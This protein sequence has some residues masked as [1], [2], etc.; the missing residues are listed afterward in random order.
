MKQKT[1]IK[2]KKA[3]TKLHNDKGLQYYKDTLR[4]KD[5]AAPVISLP[6][7]VKRYRKFKPNIGK[8]IYS[9][10]FI[11]N[12]PQNCNGNSL[13]IARKLLKGEVYYVEGVLRIEKDLYHHGWL[14][15]PKLKCY[16]DPTLF[17]EKDFKYYISN[18]ISE[19]KNLTSLV[20]LDE[21]NNYF[22]PAWVNEGIKPLVRIG[23]KKKTERN[24]G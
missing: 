14:Y 23:K 16:I 18:K 1:H 5:I 3:I 7:F 24:F 9:G 12:E 19:E 8:L 4:K 22:N 20:T 17:P 10:S 2:E 15:S 21:V 13:Y 11:P 6:E